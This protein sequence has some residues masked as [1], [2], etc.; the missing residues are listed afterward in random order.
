MVVIGNKCEMADERQVM[1][2]AATC[3]ATR[4]KCCFVF[5]LLESVHKFIWMYFIIRCFT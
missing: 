3:W 2:E 5:H 1:T 4:E